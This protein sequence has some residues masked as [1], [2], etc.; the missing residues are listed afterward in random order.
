M[1]QKN[2]RQSL[3]H[4]KCFETLR[5]GRCMTDMEQRASSRAAAA[6]ADSEEVR[7]YT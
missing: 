2:S 3:L 1:L 5:S 6:A 7:N 4:T